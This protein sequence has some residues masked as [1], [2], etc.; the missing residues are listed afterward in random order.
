MY[1]LTGHGIFPRH[2]DPAEARLYNTVN[3]SLTRY[4]M[5]LPPNTRELLPAWR[6]FWNTISVAAHPSLFTLNTQL[7]RSWR[8]AFSASQRCFIYVITKTDS[9]LYLP[10]SSWTAPDYRQNG[11]HSKQSSRNPT[12]ECL[13]FSVTLLFVKS[14]RKF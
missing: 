7:A 1:H 10:L 8:R 6:E 5:F 4:F 9:Q 3:K 11:P 14:N 2:T 12:W 13:R